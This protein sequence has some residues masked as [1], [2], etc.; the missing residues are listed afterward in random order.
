MDQNRSGFYT[1]GVIDLDILRQH[2]RKTFPCY[3]YSD[4]L[5]MDGTTQ[6]F[7]Q[8]WPLEVFPQLDPVP[9][10]IFC[11]R[12]PAKRLHS[13]FQYAKFNLGRIDHRYTFGEYCIHLLEGNTQEIGERVLHNNS[14][15]FLINALERS[16]YFNYFDHW[17]S[18]LKDR[19]KVL[20]FENLVAYPDVH[21]Q[22]C[23]AFLGLDAAVTGNKTIGWSNPTREYTSGRLHSTLMSYRSVLSGIPGKQFFAKVYTQLF[24][25]I[26]TTGEDDSKSIS[27][28][29]DHFI[30]DARKYAKMGVDIHAWQYD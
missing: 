7:Y 17:R 19:I 1:D 14:R 28:L 23:R 6:Y 5:L 20:T 25:R 4:M 16:A 13:E 9:R 30:R 15:I 12:E 24:S 8:R 10:V 2:V 21:L 27:M 3:R 22:E 26:R 18:A 29:K 11:F